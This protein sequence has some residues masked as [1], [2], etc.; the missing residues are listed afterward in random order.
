MLELTD[1]ASEDAAAEAL[2]GAV[3]SDLQAALERKPRALLLVSGGRSPLPFFAALRA[4]PLP[5]ERIDVSLV[6]ERAVAPDHPDSNAALV[7]QHLLTGFASAARFIPLVHAGDPQAQRDPWQLA[8]HAAQRANAN[9][10]L[11]A[12]DAV[13]LGMGTDGHTASLFPDSPHWKVASESRDRYVPLQPGAAPHA[14]VGL[15]LHALA[16]QRTGYLWTGGAAKS[17]TL[18]RLTRLAG[19]AAQGRPQHEVLR[20]A[21]PLAMLIAD[22][23]FTLRVFHFPE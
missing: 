1:I 15:S 2:A 17:A 19:D 23:G 7:A 4:Q 16:G 3:A 12:A 22:P 8:V 14:R 21:G 11:A 5:W 20:Q 10:D 13:V 18:A 9:A 6:D